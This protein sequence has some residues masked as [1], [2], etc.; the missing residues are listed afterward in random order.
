MARIS[1]YGL[2]APKHDRAKTTKRTVFSC[3]ICMLVLENATWLRLCSSK[4]SP[5]DAISHATVRTLC[6]GWTCISWTPSGPDT[7]ML[8]CAQV[9]HAKMLANELSNADTKKYTAEPCFFFV[10]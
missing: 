7:M 3:R 1:Q 5:L 6:Q 8:W 10:S 4:H 2:A 9:R